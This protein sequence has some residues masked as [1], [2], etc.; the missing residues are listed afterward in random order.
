MHLAR[1]KRVDAVHKVVNS[2]QRKNSVHPLAPARARALAAQ[3]PIEGQCTERS[4]QHDQ[5]GQRQGISTGQE[6]QHDDE[7]RQH[8]HI[9]GHQAQNTQPGMWPDLTS[10]DEQGIA[11]KKPVDE[12]DG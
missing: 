6:P 9:D 8:Q 10:S 7:Q 1:R 5:Q 3:S 4:E 11:C 12:T 2:D